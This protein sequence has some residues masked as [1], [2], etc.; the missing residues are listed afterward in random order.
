[1]TLYNSTVMTTLTHTIVVKQRR[2]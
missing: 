2:Y 1:M